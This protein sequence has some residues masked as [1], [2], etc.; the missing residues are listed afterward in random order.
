[1]RRDTR[2]R[3]HAMVGLRAI[4]GEQQL[5]GVLTRVIH[6]GKQALDAVMLEMGRLV[7]E[8]VMLI[9]RE[10]LAGPGLLSDG[11]ES[12]EVGARGAVDL[13]RRPEGQ[14]APPATPTCGS[15]GSA[16]AVVRTPALPRAVLRGVVGENPARGL[17]AEIRGDR[18]RRGARIRRV[19]VVNLPEDGDADGPETEGVPRAVPGGVH[20]VRD[21][22][23]HDPPGRR[24]I[25]CRAGRGRERPED[26]PG[27]LAGLLSRITRSASRCSTIWSAAVSR[28]PNGSCS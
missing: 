18:P 15:W 3:K 20:A 16:H 10:E 21:L 23:G 26:G 17:G 2:Q 7:A 13:Y 4:S 25:S 6:S 8:S 19:A 28:S 9:E 27:I 22:L 5:L 12:P 11:P 1:M 14:G 24:G